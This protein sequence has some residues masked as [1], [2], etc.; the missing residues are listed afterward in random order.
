MGKQTNYQLQGNPLVEVPIIGPLLNDELGKEVLDKHNEKFRSV[1]NITEDNKYKK[2]QPIAHSNI[3]MTLSYNQILRDISP[4]IHVLSP[5]ELVQYNAAI[6]N[7]EHAKHLQIYEHLRAH[8]NSVVIYPKGGYN[9]GL[10]Q[11]VLDI[12]GRK[13]RNLDVPLI[14]GNLDVEFE[15]N[16]YGF[17]FK[18]TP[19]IEVTNAPYLKPK[20]GDYP[21][22]IYH[23]SKGIMMIPP[24]SVDNGILLSPPSSKESGLAGIHYSLYGNFF[25]TGGKSL[26]YHD[27]NFQVLIIQDPKGHTENLESKAKE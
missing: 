15:N 23:P 13:R 18:E 5:K 20:E 25:Q 4:D 6:Q 10:K 26:L 19:F 7:L 1:V 24:N 9:E 3:P 21:K 16:E 2:G 22:L 27:D 12:I 8:T 11:Q 14:V 17:K